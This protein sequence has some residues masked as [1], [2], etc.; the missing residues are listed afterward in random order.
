MDQEKIE[1]K[2]SALR[3]V[4][5]DVD[6]V[7]TDGGMYYSEKGDELKKFSVR[8]GVGSI[9]LQHAGYRVGV[10]S[11]EKRAITE[12]RVKKIKMDFFHLGINDKK[13]CLEQ[14]ASEHDCGLQEI[15]F[16][17]DELNDAPLLGKVGLFIAPSDASDYIRTRADIVLETGGGSGV[18]REAAEHILKTTG[19][20]EK[21]AEAFISALTI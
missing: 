12:R 13:T 19:A 21:A 6:G 1:Q 20:Y 18:L 5:V 3:I 8:D 11:G 16:I 2:I 10:V 14:I 15:A 17:G 9:L 4:A 7:L